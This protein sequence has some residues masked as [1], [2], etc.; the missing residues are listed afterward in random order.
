MSRPQAVPYAIPKS[1]KYARAPP[2]ANCPSAAAGYTASP[3]SSAQLAG[4]PF[5]AGIA[6]KSYPQD[7]NASAQY[8]AS[9][10]AETQALCQ[11]VCLA[12]KSQSQT[13]QAR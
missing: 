12:A 10:P 8:Y 9:H 4:Q 6:R 3:P 2:R 5:A 11:A 13:R 7:H 1:L